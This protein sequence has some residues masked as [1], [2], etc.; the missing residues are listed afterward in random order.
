M[1]FDYFYSLELRQLRKHLLKRLHSVQLLLR[2]TR[3]IGTVSRTVATS[4]GRTTAITATG[5]ASDTI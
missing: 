3:T 5:T 1:S 4:V 2:V